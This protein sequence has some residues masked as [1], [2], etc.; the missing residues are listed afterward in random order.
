[1]VSRAF[2]FAPVF[3]IMGLFLVALAVAM[4]IS[5][6]VEA[7]R[8]APDLLPL[9]VSGAVT[10]F[11]GATMLFATGGH[12]VDL[13]RRQAFL[14]A[15]GT[16]VIMSIF[17]ALPFYVSTL[18]M[19]FTDSWF[20]AVSG[21][22][23]TGATVITG[24]NN[25]PHGILLWRAIT[26]WIGGVGIVVMGLAMLPFLKVG[27]MQ[28][29][30]MESSDRGEKFMP[31][32]HRMAG[33]ILG[34]YV[35]LTIWCALALLASGMDAF[36]AVI[37]AMT[38]VS[39]GGF[40]TYDESI[41]HLRLPAV[42]WVLVVFMI[43]GALPF[44]LYVQFL[45]TRRLAPLGDAQIRR[46]MGLLVIVVTMMT[47]W[48][49]L[50]D[51]LPIL[52]GIRLAAFNVVSIVTTTGFANADYAT[53]G[54][55][56]VV[57]FFFLTFIGGCTGSTAGG[58][59]IFRFAVLWQAVGAYIRQRI[60]P[61]EI[62]MPSFAG[63]RITDDVTTGVLMFALLVALTVTF[64]SVALSAMGLDIL[65]A[66]TGSATAV[67]NVGPGLGPII[68]PSG[69]FQSL[70]DA[71]KWVLSIDMLLG[72]LEYFTLIVVLTPAFWRD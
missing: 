41:G 36:D 38:T 56:P 53:W 69:N 20:E 30:Q 10:M 9:L 60:S 66:V 59:K 1:M 63:R 25:L 45:R 47:L 18:K 27:G 33:A 42:E 5:S 58:V 52:D 55:L 71:A 48:L 29:F 7:I 39:T 24:L 49:C 15:G 2:Y 40:S 11:V 65:T 50:V 61:N 37:H 64:S 22:T 13:N 70:P 21:L 44:G 57:I 4:W 16:W 51:G 6:M 67:S 72:R 34:V 19:S 17:A 8:Q 12:D 23:T 31:Q 3:R 28:L 46:F 35:L 14:V 32:I 62:V 68:G 54:T 43:L 26:Q